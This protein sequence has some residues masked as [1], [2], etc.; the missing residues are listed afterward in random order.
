MLDICAEA[1]KSEVVLML[2]ADTPR[3]ADFY[4]RHGFKLIQ[5]GPLLMVRQNEPV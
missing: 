4:A 2:T 3:L 1:D 5:D